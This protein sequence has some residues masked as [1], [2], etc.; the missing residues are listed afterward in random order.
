MRSIWKGAVT[1][2][3]VNIPVK[4]YSAVESSSLDLD[5]LDKKTHANIKYKRVNEN[6]GKEVEYENIVKGYKLDDEYVVLDPEDFKAADAKKTNT[7]EII[8]FVNENEID[9]VYFEQPYFLEPEKTGV[10]AYALLR[11]ALKST[12]MVGVATFVMRNKEALAIIK[13]YKNAIVLNRIRFAEEIR[14]VNNLN[15]PAELHEKKGIA[16]AV[17]LIKQL[18]EKFN[19][20]QYKD[21][22]SQ[23]LLKIIKQKAKGVKI[24]AP[25]MQVVRANDND[26]V[27][28]LKASLEKKRKTG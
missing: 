14:D 19:I 25:K 20:S 3:L 13:P 7:I 16:M 5:L 17:Q 4:L 11:S 2:G 22:Y 26:L 8:S 23:K 15:L 1:F 24:K 6:T 21:E 18:T 10:Q 12:N 27:S 9:S 28:M